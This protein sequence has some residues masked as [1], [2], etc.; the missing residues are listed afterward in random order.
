MKKI[1]Y[2]ASCLLLIAA[3]L[4]CAS[5]CGTK[6]NDVINV[7]N[8][9]EYIDSSLIPEFE[10]ETGI[11]VNYST[12]PTCEEMYAKIRNGGVNYDIVVPSDY[13]VSRMIEEGMLEKIDFD[14]VPNFKYVDESFRNPEYDPENEYSVPYQWGTVG[15]VYNKDIVDENE[16]DIGS[17]D[18]LWNQKYS[19]QILMFDNSRDAIGIALK[20]MGK[21]YNVTSE[22][23]IRAA[24]QLLIDEKPLVQ[25]YVQDQ[26]FDKI[27][28]EEAAIAPC[29]AGD[30]FLMCEELGE[31][32]EEKLGFFTPEEGSNLY[33]DAMCIPAGSQ[34]KEGA[35]KFINFICDPKNMAV[36][37]E[38][39]YYSTAESAARDL[40]PDGMKHS[41][42]MYP[43]GNELNQFETFTNLPVNC[44]RLYDKLWIKIMS[45]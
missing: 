2:A 29:Y 33:V 4:I 39:I 36:N 3:M 5:S 44:R 21:S 31:G 16:S 10:K 30:Y 32:S 6:S 20:K 17:W 28:G 38:Y 35:E 14:N 8:W 45:A 25:A 27:E 18:L 11:H 43:S 19:K 15:V 9:G 1:I 26:I 42:V 34:N 41:S 24:A 12:A 7:F 22:D 23:D 40:L 37:T 13:M